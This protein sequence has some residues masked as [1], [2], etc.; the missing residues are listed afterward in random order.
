MVQ[1]V[2]IGLALAA[3]SLTVLSPCVLPVLPLILGRS[4]DSHRLGPISLVLGLVSGFAI[5][6]S[7]LGLTVSGLAGFATVL[8]QIAIVTLI[9]IGLLSIFPNSG[10]RWPNWLPQFKETSDRG[11]KREFWIG[12]QLGLL[13]TPCAG[14]V[15][16]SILVLAAVQH[17]VIEV[18]GLLLAYGLG[19]GIP[20]L[21][22]A[23]MGRHLS[24]SLL[25]LRPHSRTIQRIGGIMI[26]LT[27][28]A[29]L[30][31]WDIEI[32]L[33]LAPWFPQLML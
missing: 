20:L 8:R 10:F 11:L 7:L 32:Q 30:Q 27:A 3:G 28:I 21:L 2:S 31:G 5:A 13:W 15:L 33:L 16:A 24:R 17:E 6:G 22:I 9:G 4:L 14:P 29:I 26:T 18:F 19:A 1:P 12:T 25:R 23:Y